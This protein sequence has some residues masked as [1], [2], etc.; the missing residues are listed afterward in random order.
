MSEEVWLPAAWLHKHMLWV[1]HVTVDV[2]SEKYVPDVCLC[3]RTEASVTQHFVISQIRPGFGLGQSK[4]G[5]G[6]LG[7]QSPSQSW[8]NLLF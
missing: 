4:Q 5:G 3:A 2:W 1:E 7:R 6:V 8:P